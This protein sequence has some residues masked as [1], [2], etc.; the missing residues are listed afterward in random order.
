MSKALFKKEIKSNYKLILIFM[1][2]LTMYSSMIISMFDPKLGDKLNAFMETM[3]DVFSAFGMTD[4]GTTLIEFMG[5]YLYGFLYIALP[6]VFIL[7]LSNKLIAR[8][9]DRGSMAYLLSTG[10]KRRKIALSQ[11]MFMVMS[12][13]I[14]VVFVTVLCIG[15]SGAIFPDGLNVPKLLVLNTGLFGL[16]LFLSGMCFFICCVC[17]DA[18]RA[19]GISSAFTIGFLLVQMVSQ[20]GDKFEFLKYINPLTLFE[21]TKII[22]GETSGVVMFCILYGAAIVLFAMGTICFNRRDLSI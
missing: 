6:A 11:A 9:I 3:P 15:V 1:A 2:V 10:N 16:L 12:I 8:Y 5:N 14:L 22:S 21:P 17:N 4:S 7:I 19:V 18:K 20:V 13:F